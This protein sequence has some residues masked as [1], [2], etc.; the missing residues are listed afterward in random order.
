[1]DFAHIT[2]PYAPSAWLNLDGLD[3]NIHQV[4]Q[5]TSNINLRI[6]SKSIRS[7]DVLKYIQAKT[8]N[9]IGIMSFCAQES[10]YLLGN[11]FDNVLCAYPTF[12]RAGI[13]KTLPY[14]Q[15]GA[16]M[17][18]MVD[19]FEQWQLLE[20]IGRQHNQ[21]LQVCLDINMS[22]PLPKLYFGTKRSSLFN[23]SDI[24]K[25]LKQTKKFKHSKLTAMMGYEG[26]IAGLPETLPD[27]AKLAPAIRALKAL[28]KK[29]VSKR[30]QKIAYWLNKNNHP[31]TLVNGG[32]SGSMA[33]TCL[34]PEITEITV[35]SA[36][37][38]PALFSYM[39]SMT[40]FT[41]SAGFVLPVTRQP[42]PKV[43]TCHSGGFVAS[44]AMGADK[45]PQIVYPDNLSILKDEGYGE[46]QTPMQ[47]TGKLS[48]GI[49]D[50]VWCRHAKAGEL[51]EHFNELITYRKIDNQH[52]TQGS[53]TTYRG[54]GQCFH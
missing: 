50:Y 21:T 12:D 15:N 1:M 44:G 8:P 16:T 48:V 7:I 31:L 39:D 34:Q 11:G 10:A 23:I 2:P 28:S 38:Y 40:N 33:F 4:N 3:A 18:W 25:L 41:P 26:Q 30:R 29:Q 24:K 14:C 27:K 37:Y 54:D 22:M 46:V 52:Q 20:E 5:M 47:A 36:Y 51:C 53:I 45:V 9:F 17:I 35:G 32:G 43:I 19:S 6:A 49:G 13:I 42:E